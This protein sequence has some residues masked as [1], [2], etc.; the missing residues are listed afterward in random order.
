MLNLKLIRHM[1]TNFLLCFALLLAVMTQYRCVKGYDTTD[2]SIINTNPIHFDNMAIGQTSQYIGVV[3]K[4]LSTGQSVQTDDTLY[5]SV[6]G[7]NNSGF[8]VSEVFHWVGF[9]DPLQSQNID[10]VYLYYVRVQNDTLRFESTNANPIP[11]RLFG[12]QALQNGLPLARFTNQS[13]NLSGWTTDLPFCTCQSTGYAQ[14]QTLLGVTYDYLNIAV[15][16][17]AMTLDGR[18]ETYVYS[19]ER[20]IVRQAIYNSTPNREGFAWDLLPKKE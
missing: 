17:T 15:D 19:K 1:R 18:G 16:N 2:H 9:I 12:P 4:N 10:S 14:N 7:Q 20:G 8:L 5:V 13:A 3:G 6:I 11:S